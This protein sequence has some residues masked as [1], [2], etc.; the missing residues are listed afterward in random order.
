MDSVLIFVSHRQ[1]TLATCNWRLPA[2]PEHAQDAPRS[3][4]MVK[5]R[6]RAARRRAV[7]PPTTSHS[8]RPDEVSNFSS[9]VAH[10]TAQRKIS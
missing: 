10:I 1:H 2:M 7:V 5:D 6:P 3:R 4:P 9:G 8:R